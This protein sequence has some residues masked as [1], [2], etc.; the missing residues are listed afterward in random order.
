MFNTVTRNCPR[1]VRHH[2]LT[3]EVDKIS[4]WAKHQSH[5]SRCI[6]RCEESHLMFWR[7]RCYCFSNE[8]WQQMCLPGTHIYRINT[9]SNIHYIIVSFVC[10]SVYDQ[11]WPLWGTGYCIQI[12]VMYWSTHIYNKLVGAS[13]MYWGITQQCKNDNMTVLLVVTDTA[14]V[15][16]LD[17]VVITS[18]I[19]RGRI[20]DYVLIANR[21]YD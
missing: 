2:V 7:N 17:T 21:R 3:T 4:H 13:T 1:R 9:M 11:V 5:D 15:R 19:V 6:K 14:S 20:S 16:G 8:I 10:V 12:I 18:S